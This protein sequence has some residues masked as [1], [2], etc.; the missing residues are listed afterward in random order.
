MVEAAVAA[1]FKTNISNQDSKSL[2]VEAAVGVL[3]AAV[4]AV[5]AMAVAAVA[6]V[7]AVVARQSR[8]KVAGRSRMTMQKVVS[9]VKSNLSRAQMGRC[10]LKAAVGQLVVDPL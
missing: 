1:I 6:A 9:E 10:H 3:V 5:A 8:R 7:A 4:A 2:W